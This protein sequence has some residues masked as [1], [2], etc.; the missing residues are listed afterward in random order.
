MP[1][2]IANAVRVAGGSI[3]PGVE[4]SVTPGKQPAIEGRPRSGRQ[5]CDFTLFAEYLS[6]INDLFLISYRPLRGLA[7]IFSAD[8]GAH[9]SGRGPQ[10]SIWAGVG[11]FM[12]S[13]A[14]RTVVHNA[15]PRRQ[16]P[17]L[18]VTIFLLLVVTGVASSVPAQNPA[19]NTETPKKA[20]K[21]PEDTAAIKREP[22]D[23]VSLEM[24]TGQCVTLETEQGAIV[25]EVL[26]AKAPESARNFLNLA[27]TGAFD[28]TT[29]SRVVPGFVI[30]GGDLATGEKWNPQLSNRAQKRLPDEPSDLKHVRGVVSMARTNQPN[31][32]TTHFFILVGD[33]PHLDGTFSAFGRVRRGIEVADAINRAPSENEKPNVPVRI[34]RAEVAGCGK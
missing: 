28:T 9:T 32:A 6:T 17:L 5:T 16:F 10:P 26:P 8:P 4:R 31:S 11:V 3:K 12:P 2:K 27:A 18:R 34:T 24:M 33:G 29:F 7:A 25:I 19:P 22:F 20:N 1:K 21:R 30:Q 14:P 13:S 15:K 23:G